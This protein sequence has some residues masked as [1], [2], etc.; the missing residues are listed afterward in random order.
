MLWI[1]HILTPYTELM[2]KGVVGD[3]DAV[4]QVAILVHQQQIVL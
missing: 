1:V 2:R 3:V 4:K